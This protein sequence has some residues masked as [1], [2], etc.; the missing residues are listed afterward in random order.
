MCMHA[1]S[2]EGESYIRAETGRASWKLIENVKTG[3][4]V[5][6]MESYNEHTLQQREG[7]S[8]ELLLENRSEREE[9]HGESLNSEVAEEE[10]KNHSPADKSTEIDNVKV[11]DS[12]GVTLSDP[13]ATSDDLHDTSS[14]EQDQKQEASRSEEESA[15]SLPS[16]E[17][18]K[19]SHE[20][21]SLSHGDD[22]ANV[23]TGGGTNESTSAGDQGEKN[24]AAT[25]E[26]EGEKNEVIGAGEDDG[27]RHENMA[28]REDEGKGAGDDKGAENEGV[29]VGE[30]K[31]DEGDEEEA[32]LNRNSE[33]S[34]S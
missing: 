24:G 11:T 2:K 7:Q 10:Q 16:E 9:E 14:S 30:D 6:E 31:Q 3:E 34:T 32:A 19:K 4:S 26:D 27:E 22:E 5:E 21:G 8:S 13:R 17:G 25:G 29:I 23:E 1:E 28:T 20:E 18:E 12:E 15:V 33:I